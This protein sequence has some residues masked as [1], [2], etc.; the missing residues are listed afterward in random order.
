MASIV[1]KSFD[2]ILL[3]AAC[4]LGRAIA[5]A[6]ARCVTAPVAIE[7]SDGTL[8]RAALVRSLVHA[9]AAAPAR[10]VAASIVTQSFDGALLGQRGH[11]LSCVRLRR[12]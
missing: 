2:G 10:C 9:I 5:A 1:T 7:T 3:R 8:L 12:H 11:I 6:P 4:S